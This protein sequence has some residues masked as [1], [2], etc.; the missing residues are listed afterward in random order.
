VY[1]IERGAMHPLGA[2]PDNGGLAAARSV[3]VLVAG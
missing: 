2:V 3:V 1:Q